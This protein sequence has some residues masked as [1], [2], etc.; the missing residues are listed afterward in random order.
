VSPSTAYRDTLE[1][2]PH[3]VDV[4]ALL[5]IAV[6]WN[7][8]MACNRATADFMFSSHLMNEP[9]ERILPDYQEHRGRA[10]ATIERVEPPTLEAPSSDGGE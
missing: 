3:D 7:I 5:R 2:Q 4:M 8:P 6:V 9:Y 10:I 1:P